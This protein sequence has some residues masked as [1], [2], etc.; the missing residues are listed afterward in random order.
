VDTLHRVINFNAGWRDVT[1][2]LLVLLVT[3]AALLS[4]GTAALG[5]KLR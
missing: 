3:G 1:M 4:L 2:N 5:R